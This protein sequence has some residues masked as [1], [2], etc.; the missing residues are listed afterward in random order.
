MLVLVAA[1][2]SALAL[3]APLAAAE[4][5]GATWRWAPAE[6]PPPPAGVP[7]ASFPPPLGHVGDIEFWAPNRGLLIAGGGG[8]SCAESASATVPCGL[9]AYNGV[10]WHLLSTVCGGAGGRIAWA[11]PDEFW[12]I[13]DQRPGQEVKPDNLASISL[14]HFLNGQVVG[15]Y[16][17]PLD[18][19]NSYE[20]MDAA[21]CLSPEDC[22]FGG[23]RGQAPNGGAFHLHWDGQN[24]NVVY[25][26][27]NHKVIS[28]ALAN[29]STLLESVEV[30]ASDKWNPAEEKEEHPF[31]LHQIQPFGSATAFENLL[32]PNPG[33]AGAEA[34]PTLPDYGTD[35]S[36]KPVSP[37]SFTG[38]SLSSD[39]TP[40]GTN[41]EAP[42]LWAVGGPHLTG[43][44]HPLALRYSEGL[45]TQVVGN[46]EPG[47]GGPFKP[48]EILT[49]VAAEPGAAAAWVTIAS[50]DGQ[51]HVDRLTAEGKISA[52]ETLGVA[53]GVGERGT[54][55]PIAC[56][57][58]H[59]CWL[60]TS[61]GWLFHLTDGSTLPRDTDPN[62]ESV[63]TFRPSDPGVPQLPPIEPPPDDS[64]ANQEAAPPPPPATAVQTPKTFTSKALVT[65]V[66]SHV[67]HRDMLEL[68]FTLTVKAHVQLLASRKNRGVAHTALETLKAGKHTLTLRLNT[69]KWPTK[70]DLKATPLEALPTVESSGGDNGQTVAPPVKEN[71]VS[72]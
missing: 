71:T 34:C 53:Q 45:W 24:V 63:I 19:P 9:Y 17:M 20:E 8:R 21:T 37:E 68:S 11:G 16:A 14:C 60:A 42:Q 44:A 57:A 27:A 61:E 13:S 43:N 47:G 29:Q 50:H 28:M 3:T 40:S 30:T 39:F 23:L 67:V 7:P 25:S 52:E 22:W 33:C 55:G 70:L 1:V 69:R 65:G 46:D 10:G 18:Q 56:P 26:S 32:I 2:L 15:S 38:F 35:T 49:G 51:A 41:L 36:G 5:A 48:G 59:E 4:D 72:T 66:S 54:A 58:P 62:F 6:A 31:L 64:L 12:T